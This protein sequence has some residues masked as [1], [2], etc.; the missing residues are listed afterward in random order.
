L[1]RRKGIRRRLGLAALLVVCLAAVGALGARR[2]GVDP[3]HVVLAPNFT[4]TQPAQPLRVAVWNIHGGKGAR[5]QS[6]EPIV[7]GLTGVDLAALLEVHA[8]FDWAGGNQAQQL[9]ERLGLQSAFFPAERRFWRDHLGGALLA[10]PP[11]LGWSTRPLPCTQHKG[12]RSYT[13][14]QVA[15][16][17]Q[18]LQCLVAHLDRRQDRETQLRR[19]LDEF[20]KLP[21]PALLLGDLNTV[22][23]DPLLA[24]FLKTNDVA[25]PLAERPAAA[26]RV[27]WILGRGVR[28]ASA[29]VLHNAGS[30]HPCFWADVAPADAAVARPGE[31][32]RR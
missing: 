4:R 5:G 20:L 27:D 31:G 8:T 11:L 12:F 14:A 9:G 32:V 29:G 7:A 22:A 3:I 17:D 28:F 18:R 26:G 25:D 13:V 21:A 2:T 24:A 23:E 10:R 16:G 15:W 6:L 19:V 30:D 1:Q